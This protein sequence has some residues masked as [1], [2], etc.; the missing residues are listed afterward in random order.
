MDEQ[1]T[2]HLMQAVWWILDA[3]SCKTSS[4]SFTVKPRL[5]AGMQQRWWCVQGGNKAMHEIKEYKSL[6]SPIY[7]TKQKCA[8]SNAFFSQKPT[9]SNEL[10]I[11][12][13]MLS[14]TKL[15]ELKHRGVKESLSCRQLLLLWW[16]LV[17]VIVLTGRAR[18]YP[19]WARAVC[20]PPE[21]GSSPPTNSHT[22]SPSLWQTAN[23]M[24]LPKMWWPRLHGAEPSWAH[25]TGCVQVKVRKALPS[26]GLQL[27]M[28]D[29]LSCRK[30]VL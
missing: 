5:W 13:L 25:G 30:T 27:S 29:G 9:V 2:V 12:L 11:A 20:V 4:S 15:K 14:Q 28:N 23:E 22:R 18:G 1:F 21:W 26:F 10:I 7:V 17:L 24:S 6:F 3:W 16:W 19:E 8:V